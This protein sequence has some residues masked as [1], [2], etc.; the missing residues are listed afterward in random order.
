MSGLIVPRGLTAFLPPPPVRLSPSLNYGEVN[1][2][3][4]VIATITLGNG[5]IQLTSWGTPVQSGDEFSVTAKVTDNSG[6]GIF[7]TLAIYGV[8]HTYS[9]GQL[10]AGNYSFTLT[11]CI[12]F[13]QYGGT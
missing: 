2:D 6:P 11:A 3:S 9:L 13:P 12:T 8:H 1:G 5:C 7:C 4:Q 10:A